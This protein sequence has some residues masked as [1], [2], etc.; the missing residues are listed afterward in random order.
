MHVRKKV[1]NSPEDRLPVFIQKIYNDVAA[2][3]FKVP[4]KLYYT[5]TGSAG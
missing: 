1:S 3:S 5:Y 2:S 4:Y